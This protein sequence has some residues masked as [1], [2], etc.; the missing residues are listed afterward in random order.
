MA[1]GAPLG[2]ERWSEGVMKATGLS[3]SP[4]PLMIAAGLE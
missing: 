3:N 1:P 4:E 2:D